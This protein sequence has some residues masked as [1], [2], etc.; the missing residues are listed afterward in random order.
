MCVALLAC[1]LNLETMQPTVVSDNWWVAVV[2]QLHLTAEQRH[3]VVLAFECYRVQ[4]AS[5]LQQQGQLVEQLRSLLESEPPEQHQGNSSGSDAD[6]ALLTS[7]FPGDSSNSA[8]AGGR[9]AGG[10]SGLESSSNSTGSM[11]LAL[12]NLEAAMQAEAV[13]A[14]LERNI[15]LQRAASRQL[16]YFWIDLLTTEQHT[17]AILEAYP[18]NIK[19][20]A[21]W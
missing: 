13:L 14:N 8:D 19:I 2:Q 7:C 16:T 10:R 3:K 1:S 17:D 21:G 11:G 6:V 5:L 9:S 12:M 4:R 18:H 15:K 20:P